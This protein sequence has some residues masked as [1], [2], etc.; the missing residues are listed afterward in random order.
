MIFHQGESDSTQD[1]RAAWPGRVRTV[2]DQ[3]R[4]D[5]A[6][7]PVP[8]LAGELPEGG[9]CGAHNPFIA[10]LPS[11]ITEAYVVASDGLGILPDG[12]HFHRDAQR[13]FGARYGAVMIDALGL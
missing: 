4:S 13:E 8:F 7:G 11:N 10:Q 2:V 6:I 1:A 3:L 5:L 9:C 12:L